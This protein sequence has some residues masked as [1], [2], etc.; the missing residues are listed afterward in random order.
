VQ[1]AQYEAAALGCGSSSCIMTV[2]R[3]RAARRTSLTYC[4]CKMANKPGAKVG[5]VLPQ[6]GS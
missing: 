3:S 4:L 2:V 1:I 6:V 5:A